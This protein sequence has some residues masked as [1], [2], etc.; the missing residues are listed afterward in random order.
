MPAS[1]SK[2]ARH[3]SS[4][5]RLLKL[6]QRILFDGAAATEVVVANQE[7]LPESE[8]QPTPAPVGEPATETTPREIVFIDAGVG[9]YQQLIDGA[10]SDV[11][12]IVLDPQADGLRQIADILAS[13][14]DLSAIHIVSHGTPG[15]ITLGS[16]LLN[17][18]TLAAHSELIAA[19]G[20]SLSA[21][22]DL[23]IYG[24]RV[25][26][27]DSPLITRLAELTRADVAASTDD[28]GLGGNWVLERNAGDI[29]TTTFLDLD[30]VASYAARLGTITLSGK[31]GWTAVM[32]G[33][34]KDPAGDSQA[35]AADTD[36]IGDATHGSFYV[37]YDDNGTPDNPNDDFMA[38][39]LRIDN[40]TSSTYFGGVAVV[41][42]DANGDGR[43]DLFMTVDGRN[44]TQ[45][46]RLMDPG[47]GLNNSPSTTTTSP[48]PTGW[49]PNNGIYPFSNGAIYNVTAV[50]AG[51]DPN[52]GASAMSVSGSSN[53]LT[54]DGK[55]DVFVSWKI[56]IADIA[57]V[58]AKASPV[59]RNGVYGPRGATGIQGFTKDTLVSYVSFTQTQPGPINGDLN[60]VG[61]SYD[62]NA[63]FADLGTFTTPMSPSNPVSSAD[64]VRIT[65]PVDANGLINASEDS[66]VV[67]TGTATANAW[68][69]LTVSDGSQTVTLWTQA[70][71]SGS[72]SVGTG[73][74]SGFAEGP[75]AIS[76]QL[77]TGNG[78]HTLV[79]GASGDAAAVTH[80]SIAPAI[81]VQPLATSGRPT[82]SGTTDL[83]AGS[84][85]TVSIDPNGDGILSDLVTYVALV[86]SGGTWS[87]NT[88]LAAPNSGSLPSTG[89]TAFARVTVQGQDSAGNSTSVVALDAPTVRTLTTNDTTP[90]LTGTWLNVPGDVL[91]V[92][93]NGVTYTA[94]DGKLS[95]SGNTWSLTIP[96]GNAL[97]VAS[98]EVTAQVS[99]GGSAISD[100][101]TGELTITSTPVKSVDINGGDILNTG[102]IWPVLSGTSQNAG[103]FVIVRLDPNNDGDLSDAVTYSVNT[104]GSGNWTLNSNSQPI[105]GQ[106]PAGGYYGAVGVQVTDS[107]GS[108][109]DSQILN[110]ATPNVAITSITSTA[111][112]NGSALVSNSGAGANWLNMTEDDAVTIAGTASG[113]SVDL[114]ITDVNGN[115]IEL[116]GISVTGGNWSAS[117]LNLSTLDNGTLTITA[118]LSNTAIFDT[119]TSVTHDKLAPRIFNTTPGEIKKNGGVISGGSELPNTQLT[120]IVR[121]SG[122]TSTIWSS[123][124]V[125]TDANGDWSVT[126][127]GNLVSGA[128]GTVI[129]KVQPTTTATDTAGNISQQVP[130]SQYVAASAS[131]N[132]I[133]IGTI[134][135]DNIISTS[136]IAGGVTISG[137]TTLTGS[138]LISLTVSDGTTTIP[139]STTA[140]SGN[141]SVTLSN[142]QIKTL[143]NG[144]LTVT[145]T[146][147]D[148]TITIQDVALPTLS[149]PRPQVS[150]T[151]N[152][153][154]TASGDVLFTFTFSEPVSGFTVGDIALTNG[155]AGTF[156][157]IDASTYTLLVTPTP[158]SSGNITV[159]V[160]G[161]QATSTLTGRGNVAGDA[162][163]PF[164]TTGAATPP[165]VTI[166]TDAL[167]SDRTPVI[168]GTT[169]LPAGAPIVIDIDLDND[170]TTDLRYAAT[171]QAG[172]NWSIDLDTA[173]PSSGSLPAD[174]V[175]PDARVT[176]TATNAFG[177]ST[178]ATGLNKPSVASQLT[179]DSTPTISGTWTNVPGD[180]LSIVVGGV[181]YAQASGNLTITG[182]IWS[183]TPTTPLAD[184]TY[185]VTARV[186][187]GG[188]DKVDISSSEVV[189]DT[190]PPAV[191]I[192]SIDDDTGASLSDFLTKDNTLLFSGTA[193]TNSNVTITLTNAAGQTLFSTTVLA[194]GGNWSVDRR[195]LP[196]LADG[197][198]TLTAVA[199]DAAG[200]T[201][202][203]IQ[204]LVVDTQAV[205]GLTVGYKA[206]S[207]TPILAGTTDIEPGR[208]LTVS[209][210]ITSGPTYTYST[211]V[212]ADGTWQVNTALATPQGQGGPVSFADGSALT[213]TV[214]GTDAAG[215][216]AEAQRS[217]VID[218]SA[219]GI[220]INEPLDWQ[221]N[222]NGTLTLA[223]DGSV[224]IRGTTTNAPAGTVLTITLTDGTQ[225]LSDTAIV[226]SDGSWALAP[227]SLRSFASGTITVTATL[228]DGAGT[229]FTDIATVLHDKSGSISID[230]ISSDTGTPGDFITSDSTLIFSGSATPGASVTLSLSG[231]GGTF[232][233]HAVTAN[234]SGTWTYDYRGTSL[235]DGSYTLTATVG[236][237][238]ASQA[239]VVD[240]G[241]PTGPLS[242]TA[243][244]TTD[245]TPTL[246]GTATLASGETLSVS[247]NGVTYRVGDGHLTH[248]AGTGT[249]SLTIPP[250]NAL[251]PAVSGGF[252]GVYSVVASIR[253]TAGNLLNDA[254]SNELTITL[255]VAD[256]TPPTITGPSA[257]TGATSSKSIAEN[258][259][260][261]HDFDANESVT[262]TLGGADAGKF[263]I[264]ADGK[265]VFNSAPDYENPTDAGDTAG[266]N[267]YVVTVTATDAAGNATTQTVTV[268][269]TNVDE[270]AP[271]ISGP[272]GATGA[273]SSKSVAENTTDVHDFA[274]NE[275]VTWTLGG[276]DAGK[277][278]IDVD[279]KLVFATAPDYENPTDAGDTALNNTY[280]VT[281]TATDASGNATTQT[282]TVT[283]TNVDEIAPTITGP[284]TATGAT[285]SKSIAENTTDVHDF[286]ANESVTWT[287]GGAD[288]GKF[289]IDA[290]G[291]LVFTTAPDFENPTD[292]GDTAGN[293]TYVVTV[294]ATDAAGNAT[295]QTVT[296]TVT[297][298]DESAPPAPP[299]EPEVPV[300]VQPSTPMFTPSSTSEPLVSFDL[301]TTQATL[302]AFG[303][304]VG[305]VD[306]SAHVL[307]AVEAVRLQTA[308]GGEEAG[309]TSS[310]GAG[311]GVDASLHV[312]PAV[313]SL[314]SELRQIGGQIRQLAQQSFSLDPL[315]SLLGPEDLKRLIGPGEVANTE[316]GEPAQAAAEAA[317]PLPQA[318]AGDKPAVV[319]RQDF[320]AQLKQA[321][322]ARDL[323]QFARSLA[324]AAGNTAEAEAAAAAEA[325]A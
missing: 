77:V 195:N 165:S 149:L 261:V 270:V 18:S 185:E 305:A 97:A 180:T 245:T 137:T 19:W 183:L 13:R 306:P 229:A 58:L 205:I 24:C 321:A 250:A 45:A 74:L 128:S 262:W 244:S 181:T 91:T 310:I 17:D 122:D 294:T 184:G 257:A 102:D 298:V 219:P 38:F 160:A 1:S 8:T 279:G 23:L 140:S 104:D 22:G 295:T 151:D 72:W 108:V 47:T 57:T 299:P 271:T 248:D 290:D 75:L 312:L 311:L 53:D 4:R 32:Y 223:E 159:A 255:P 266:N 107:T 203:D 127:S 36:I 213:L 273:T 99:R 287:R 20:N 286:D 52:W 252:N 61:S 288:A 64:A 202:S 258:T 39:R 182:N 284:S 319:A 232:S 132:T 93:V 243:L 225:T 44:N 68:V 29:E 190:S 193:E 249:W 166:N 216:A 78:S 260:D 296:V 236:G 69:K 204:T 234:P 272:S 318:A 278:S 113:G 215:N 114:L 197:S 126:T 136:E 263:S 259:T 80:D 7:A 289:S 200:N 40:P 92:I 94:G 123:T 76:A 67:I 124:S 176:A 196:A 220:A 268:T 179:A 292:A 146:A 224:T 70:N 302:P 152:T 116:N 110:I 103:G 86:G 147:P 265:L 209:V 167:A 131:S 10:R 186:S 217:M 222:G 285:S 238:N 300:P 101:T 21:D 275:S 9:D 322:S 237:S 119:D 267:T 218:T 307:A 239:I 65:T 303:S 121:D 63:S 100:V 191:A 309:E 235:P 189:I 214:S 43:I 187:R 314:G 291:K 254:T 170:G 201:A 134:A 316:A 96:A 16:S 281:V 282:V 221:G 178:S 55:T 192:T 226:Q 208:T 138:P 133:S 143:A 60:G 37:A 175:P 42:M 85:L 3:G 164:E 111:S 163:Q 227:L 135:G 276:A 118:T 130:W 207:T 6:E 168:S 142:A 150:I 98:Y 84:Q 129:I 206:A 264:D 157:Q 233:N 79:V 194:S 14:N 156:T 26:E 240:T 117:G 317:E 162:L 241:T 120:V 308:G 66:N 15:E 89:L 230:S 11:E 199:T 83:P 12:V 148:G 51:S 27:G 171:V 210:A 256:T 228:V 33:T 304:Q 90:T 41:G 62:K 324:P 153:P 253:D 109:A 125:L 112:S 25:G 172:G 274:A 174:G 145:A 169:S 323:A 293:N 71:G 212:A 82:I 56:P 73:D 30:G 301:G 50:T 280:V 177:N 34:G 188:T 87:V 2:T 247:V 155:T 269:V 144:P 105:A 315:D 231:P 242:V 48:I 173:Q 81:T 54:G 297:N 59:D 313:G 115:F 139:L 5:L 31:D 211:T 320:S 251:S 158:N 246:V 46:V 154:G 283:V 88:A 161:N 49:L 95:V 141:W 106:R 277:F 198:Y 35:G 325:N 28:T